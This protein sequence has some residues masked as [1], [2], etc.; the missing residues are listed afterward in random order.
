MLLMILTTEFD[1]ANHLYPH[2]IGMIYISRI[3][4]AVTPL[5]C[6]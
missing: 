1:G 3:L 6:T 5:S 4:D 2:V